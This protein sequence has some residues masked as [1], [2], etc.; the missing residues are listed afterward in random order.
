MERFASNLKMKEIK[1]L[2]QDKQYLKAMKILESLNV[3]KIRSMSDLSV[4]AEVLISN[5]EYEDAMEILLRIYEKSCSRKV[6]EQLIDLSIKMK[7]MEETGEYY[8]EYLRIAPRDPYRLVLQYRIE[9]ATHMPYAQRINT[10]E[11]LKQ[12][13]YMEEWAYE[14]AKLYHKAGQKNKCV[15]ECSDI[16]LWFGQG[17]VVE[18]ARLL[19][20]HYTSGFNIT[21]NLGAGEFDAT[22]SLEEVIKQ[23]KQRRNVA[24]SQPIVS[25]PLDVDSTVSDNKQFDNDALYIDGGNVTDI[26]GTYDDLADT[27]EIESQSIESQGIESQEI[28]PDMIV[29][30]DEIMM[31][32][33]YAENETSEAEYI[34][35][36]M[37][38]E[39]SER[40]ESEVE[41]TKIE[42]P[43]I[44]VLET[45]DSQ[46]EVQE[47]EL[48]ITKT[49]KQQPEKEESAATQEESRYVLTPD[50]VSAV[51]ARVKALE[52]E[53]ML[54]NSSKKEISEEVPEPVKEEEI[55]EEVPAP[56][57]EKETAEVAPEPTKEE[58]IPK[59]EKKSPPKDL[60]LTTDELQKMKEKMQ[61]LQKKDSKKTYNHD[62]YDIK[63]EDGTVY[64]YGINLNT[65]FQNFINND[66]IKNQLISILE[67]MDNSKKRN[68]FMIC[69]DSQTGKTSLARAIAIVMWKLNR[70]Q[71]K[72]VAKIS[73]LKLNEIN[74]MEKMGQLEN[75]SVVIENASFLNEKA[76]KS[77]IEMIEYFDGKIL[78]LFEDYTRNME[79]LM[80]RE[81]ELSKY[82]NHRI[83]IPRYITQDILGF[84]C[85]MIVQQEYEIEVDA[86]VYLEE[87]IA[88]ICRTTP[89][90]EQLARTK[91]YVN[92][93]IKKA[94]TRNMLLLMKQAKEGK[95][96]QN[97]KNTIAI[98]DIID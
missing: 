84:A 43:E 42:E 70:I 9:K 47:D 51:K 35:T 27:E 91:D 64:A 3:D 87:K 44:E 31:Q 88:Q 52:E 76:V 54:Y 83:I 59:E 95:F 96:S 81:K 4:I 22:R 11:Q 12:E 56:V 41:E 14:L 20:E 39:E 82:F 68:N 58:E 73:A 65:I 8:Q 89:S 53:N 78:V 6:V 5:D 97:V 94:E 13:D 2:A 40:E 50:I 1:R 49:E 63:E 30:P 66:S 36:Q 32:E 17:I 37:V 75:A 93:L 55:S 15:E 46:E 61:Q 38:A 80:A 48:P 74:L 92:E 45:K 62:S 69:G 29:I 72:R 16:I 85:N 57:K 28:I 98:D 71:T 67:N 24:V 77:I 19:K 60:T 34:E 10:L 26:E 7:N 90:I 21:D 33:E 79:E 18:K 86:V 25:S 23:V